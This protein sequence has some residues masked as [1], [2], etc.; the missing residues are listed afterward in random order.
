MNGR[1]QVW[2]I[3]PGPEPDERSVEYCVKE[4]WEFFVTKSAAYLFI[5]DRAAQEASH[6]ELGAS[7]A[8]AREAKAR[9]AAEGSG[10]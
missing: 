2:G 8:R 7:E 4:S 1:T 3:S 6:K 5:A 9:A 10:A